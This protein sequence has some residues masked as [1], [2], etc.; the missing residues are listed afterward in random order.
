MAKNEG[1]SALGGFG[2]A[3][4][5][6]IQSERE[7]QDKLNQQQQEFSQRSREM[8][9]LNAYR[10]KA[11]EQDQAQFGQKLGQDQW[12]F[13][14]DIDL[15]ERDMANDMLMYNS[16]LDFKQ[17]EADRDYELG[18]KQIGLGYSNLAQRQKEFELT[19]TQPSRSDVDQRQV[20]ELFGKG[21]GYLDEFKS[22]IDKDKYG[23]WKQ[24][25]SSTVSQLLEKVGVPIN[26]DVANYI[27]SVI[28]PND[29]EETRR[30]LLDE[31]INDVYSQGKIT[32][33]QKRALKIWKELGTR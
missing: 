12:Q 10:N 1:L 3:F 14:V 33:E 19:K 26:G 23:G 15:K 9:L 21:Q 11:L 4:F 20:E 7:R 31:A 27:R 17:Q 32:D 30:K 18:K 2:E 8:N 6:T 22:G 13:D 29:D 5:K 16:G 28:D 25:A 24:D